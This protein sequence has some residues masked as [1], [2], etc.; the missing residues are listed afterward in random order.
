MNSLTVKFE[1]QIRITNEGM[2]EGYAKEIK[3]YIP[4]G[5][6]FNKED[7]PLWKDESDGIITTDQ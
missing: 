1:Y 4:E 5:L 2:I 3:D 7:N 6:M